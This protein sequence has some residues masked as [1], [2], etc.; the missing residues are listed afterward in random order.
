MK[1]KTAG[2][3][4]W[5]CWRGVIDETVLLKRVYHVKRVGLCGALAFNAEKE[6]TVPNCYLFARFCP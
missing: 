1:L 4:Y 2:E 6:Q 3:S 5:V